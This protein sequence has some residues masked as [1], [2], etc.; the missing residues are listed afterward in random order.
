MSYKTGAELNLTAFLKTKFYGAVIRASK[1]ADAKIYLARA[2]AR[3]LRGKKGRRSNLA[4]NARPAKPN[5]T[6]LRF[7]RYAAQNDM[8]RLLASSG[9]NCQNATA[10]KCFGTDALPLFLKKS[11]CVPAS[12]VCGRNSVAKNSGKRA[13]FNP[14]SSLPES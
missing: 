5:L 14:K 11:V 12:V 1:I 4:K 2:W 7:V 9:R 6:D 3:K 8:L 10:T 13:K